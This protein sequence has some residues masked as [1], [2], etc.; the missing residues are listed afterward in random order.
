MDKS[1]ELL[2]EGEDSL[3]VEKVFGM[4]EKAQVGEYD[5]N[6]LNDNNEYCRKQF[7]EKEGNI[8]LQS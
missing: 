3:T 1:V 7:P 4:A 2:M 5:N 6:P 8:S